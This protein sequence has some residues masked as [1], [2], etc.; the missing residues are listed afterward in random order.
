MKTARVWEHALKTWSAAVLGL[1]VIAAGVP[2]AFGHEHEMMMPPAQESERQTPTD[3]IYNLAATW[4]AQDGTRTELGALRGK[5]Q[6]V[7]MFYTSC[8]YVCPL[9]VDRMKSIEGALTAEE[10]GQT[11]FALFS[12]DPVRDSSAVLKA[13]AAKRELDLQRW[14]LY[15]GTA[16][17]VQDLAALLGVRYRQ[18]PDGDFS[19]ST[20]ITVLD[21]Q[22]VIRYQLVELD[23][24][25]TALLQAL[26]AA[27][28]AP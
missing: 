20:I 12:F 8:Q 14:R 18:E 7:A 1:C 13:Y 23:Q 26:R 24:D 4:T 10:R 6:V 28:K 5:P 3:S 19:H 21:R 25:R 27:L 17:D 16:D 15:S 11:G 22:G 9:I 2:G